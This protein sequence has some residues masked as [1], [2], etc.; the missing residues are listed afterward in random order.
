MEKA[1]ITI[2]VILIIVF[3]CVFPLGTLIFLWYAFLAYT[4]IQK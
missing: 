4:I 1:I 3:L 2:V